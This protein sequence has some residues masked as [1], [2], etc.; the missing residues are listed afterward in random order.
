VFWCFVGLVD[1]VFSKTSTLPT[2]GDV[3]HVEFIEAFAAI[4]VDHQYA[5]HFDEAGKDSYHE[6]SQR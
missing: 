3:L 6:S 4:L 1:S 5:W 2:L